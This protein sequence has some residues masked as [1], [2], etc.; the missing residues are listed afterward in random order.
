MLY[1]FDID[2]T[3]I[4]GDGSGRR[5][6]E[7][8]CAE[9]LHVEHALSHIRLDGMTDPL[10]LDAAFEEHAGRRPTH[11]EST[12]VFEAYVHYLE[13]EVARGLYH[14]K[15]AVDET[16]TFLERRGACVGLA[17]GN[18]EAGARIKLTR[19]DLWHRFAF[20]GYGSD[21]ADRGELVRVAIGR[22]CSRLGRTLARE[23]V[24]VI[25]DTP[26]DVAAA[27]AAGALAVG[28]ATGSHD[29]EE[30]RASGADAAFPTMKEWLVALEDGDDAL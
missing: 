20:G 18:L 22:G 14:V 10:I 19:G 7:R 8:A 21:A 17:T 9:V 4:G 28:I 30:L 1:L 23:Q 2:G 13:D 25:G 27:H 24:L 5:A 26:K 11:A 3:L 12:Q 6:F 15:P 29:V 16:L